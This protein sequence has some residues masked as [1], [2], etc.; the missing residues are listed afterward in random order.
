M[1]VGEEM[2][3]SVKALIILNPYSGKIKMKKN[4]YDIINV[5]NRNGYETTLFCT[6]S[7]KEAEK[8]IIENAHLY[9]VVICCGGDGTLSEVISGI[10]QAKLKIPIGL[11]PTGTTNDVAKT[12]CLPKSLLKTIEVITHGSI[13]NY[14]IGQLDE[15]KYF[16]YIASFGAFSAV[17]Y[18]TPQWLKNKFGYFAYTLEGIKGIGDI[19]PYKVKIETNVANFEGEFIFGSITN[20]TSVGGLV[21]LPDDKVSLNDGF[22]EVMLIPHPKSPADLHKILKGLRTKRYDINGIYFTH[23]NHIKFTFDNDVKWVTDGEFGGQYKKVEIRVIK[24]KVK[25]FSSLTEKR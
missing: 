14:D 9:D 13:T 11:I 2:S 10:I 23:T 17:S 22:F 12:L 19:K 15:N 18:T 21:T 25:I 8:E 6:S 4:L 5:F 7:P 20:S 16:S 3:K 1:K 24:E